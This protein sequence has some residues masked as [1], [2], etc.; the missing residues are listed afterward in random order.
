MIADMESVT[1]VAR[2]QSF[3]RFVEVGNGRYHLRLW[4]R[5]G[6]PLMVLLHG[7]MD[8]SASFQFLVDALRGD[9]RVVAPDWRG[10]GLSTWQARPYWFPDY[11]ADLD[12]LLAVLS[13]DQ[14]LP[15]VGHSM[16]GNVA[17]LYAG[18]RPERVSHLV[19]IEGFGLAAT[20]PE[21]APG[22]YL[23]W[24]GQMRDGMTSRKYDDRAALA[25]RLMA[26][27]PRLSRER[28]GFLAEHLGVAAEGGGFELA[29]DP[30]HRALNPVL[31]R[32]DEAMACWR[33]VEAPTL[34]IGAADSFVMEAYARNPADY[35]RR[36][37]CFKS[38]QDVVFAS[39]GHNIHHEQP[40]LLAASIESFLCASPG[41]GASDSRGAC[42]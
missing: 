11:L 26:Q 28:A 41:K 4:G 13:P 36:K 29:G 42:S 39:G 16:G 1:T 14:P 6:A 17:C 8:V 18:I 33:R 3:S 22:R 40:E 9:W 20:T 19:S 10:F 34:W 27:N 38:V 12:A 35:Q 31:Y 7:W 24:L 37:A 21:E 5:E 2:R 32:L 23:R 25:D 15:L 30:W